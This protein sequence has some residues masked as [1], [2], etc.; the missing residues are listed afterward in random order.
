VIDRKKYTHLF[1][2]L[3]NTLWDFKTNSYYAMKEAFIY[4]D[5]HLNKVEFEFFFETYSENNRLLWDEYRKG[6]VKK[7]ELVR[8][9]FQKTFDALQIDGID[10]LEM[11]DFY[12]EEMTEQKRLV[13]D[14][15]AVLD[16]LKKKGFELYII[17]N[18]F[19]Q[20]QRKK[21]QS[22]G[23]G[24]YFK[25]VF[26]SEDISSPKPTLAIF[27][28]ALKSANARKTKS[29]MIGDDFE[30][31]IK[32]ALNFGIDAVYLEPPAMEPDAHSLLN[33]NT[34][35]LLYRISTL[36]EILEIV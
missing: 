31:D 2:D 12:L 26:I 15:E 10:P 30:S 8:L 16:T 24:K 13:P 33:H 11:N 20:V 34:R 21:L 23:I 35:N 27:E 19:S 9:R 3:D 18:G 36:P 7:K 17:T 28:Y 4:Y 29:I 32:G 6:K 22:A 25:K 1:F 5:R 14:A